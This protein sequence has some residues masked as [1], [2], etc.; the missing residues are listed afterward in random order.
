MP[1]KLKDMFFTEDSL[2]QF[3]YRIKKSYPK[4]NKKK[5][6]TLI[7]DDKWK[8]LELK[9][10]MRH[11]T[12]C[13]NEALPS[14]YN[15]AVKI[16]TE[17]A[18][19]IKGFE[20]MTLPDYVELYGLKDWTTSLKALGHFTKYSSSEF[21]IR[22]FLD[23]DPGKVM[24]HMLKWAG[25]KNENQRRFASEGCRPRLPWAMALPKFKKDPSLIIPILEKLKDDNSEFVRKSVAN[26]LNDISKDNPD[27]MLKVCKEWIGKS[28]RTDWIIKH[29]CRTLL[30]AGDKRALML[31]GYGDPDKIEIKRFK[32]DKEI[33]IGDSL[34][35]SFEMIN[36][37]KKTQ[38][39][40]VE[41]AIT[42]VKSK[43]KT[44]RKVFKITE[45]N[46]KP[47]KHFFNKRQSFVDISTRK[48][49][50][51]KHSLDI[52]INGEIKSSKHFN[53]IKA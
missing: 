11:T 6:M 33:R 31:F 53:L 44:S 38:T 47:G 45:N 7:F 39:V 8:S 13:L 3:A 40:R 16:L 32:A 5:F 20:S 12:L 37:D 50:P 27:I 14:D 49:F 29:A 43:G 23:K 35:Y 24:K 10:K 15:K 46:Y 41:Y 25:S 17:I 28:P 9:A 21:S 2:T 36:I 4:F 30:K 51:G 48:H 52:I 22:P 1:D 42:Y 19:D 26:N 18:P 34:N